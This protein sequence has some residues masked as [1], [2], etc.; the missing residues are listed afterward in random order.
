MR[1]QDTQG[2]GMPQQ[3]RTGQAPLQVSWWK[4]DRCQDAR[5]AG[6]HCRGPEAAL[7]AREGFSAVE[8]AGNSWTRCNDPLASPVHGTVNSRGCAGVAV[9]DTGRRLCRHLGLS[10]WPNHAE[11]KDFASR[12]ESQRLFAGREL[13]PPACSILAIRRRCCR[14]R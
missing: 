14:L 9:N 6:P 8:M 11:W 4:I 1:G 3:V 13:L 12:I 2:R 10:F 7:G 5:G